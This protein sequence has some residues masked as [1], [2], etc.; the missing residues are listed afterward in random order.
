MTDEPESTRRTTLALKWEHY[1]GAIWAPGHPC[2][3]RVKLVSWE[4]ISLL[5]F[6]SPNPRPPP[7]CYAFFP[8]LFLRCFLNK[9]LEYKTPSQTLLPGQWTYDSHCLILAFSEYDYSTRSDRVRVAYGY[10]KSREGLGRRGSNFFRPMLFGR[11]LGQDSTPSHLRGM[12]G[13]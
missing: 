11:L 7:L 5:S 2:R 4:T 8:H 1:F 3:I 9:S 6:C 13:V 12:T 10:L